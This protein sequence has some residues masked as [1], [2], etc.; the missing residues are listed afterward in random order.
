MS[1]GVLSRKAAGKFHSYDTNRRY[2]YHRSYTN[3]IGILALYQPSIVI[4]VNM[5][6]SNAG[7]A[8]NAALGAKFQLVQHG[9]PLSASRFVCKLFNY[10]KLNLFALGY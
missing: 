3:T 7:S 1:S 9:N 8:L 10:V 5:G 2:A 4:I 6:Q